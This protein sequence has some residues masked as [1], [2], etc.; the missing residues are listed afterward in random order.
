MSQVTVPVWGVCPFRS[1]VIPAEK[2]KIFDPDAPPPVPESLLGPCLQ[3]ACGLWKI[4]KLVDGKPVEGLCS[5]RFLGEVMNSIAGS[6][7]QLVKL[8]VGNRMAESRLAQGQMP[9]TFTK[10]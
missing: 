10:D 9:M 7:E 6:L 5:I 2:R 3:G 8:E 4:S 1:P